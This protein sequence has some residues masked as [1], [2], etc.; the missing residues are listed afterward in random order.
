MKLKNLLDEN[1]NS[2]NK[3]TS[4]D[5]KAAFLDEIKQFNQFG[6]IVYRTE[7]LKKVAEA[8]SQLAEKAEMITLQETEDWF[9][10]VTVKKN[11]RGLKSNVKEFNRSVAEISKL[12]QRL[13][14]IYEEIGH[15]LG[16]YYEL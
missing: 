6:S 13:E 10:E 5:E 1:F 4:I 12:Q 7:D 16:R 8:I 14:S 9:D 3:K 2:G 11:M 15:T